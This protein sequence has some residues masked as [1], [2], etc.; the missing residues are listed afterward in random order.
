MA[1]ISLQIIEIEA[2][3]LEVIFMGAAAAGYNF[4]M[5]F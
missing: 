2:F 4:S 5:Y 1:S 3:S